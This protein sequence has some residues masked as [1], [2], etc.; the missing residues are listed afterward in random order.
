MGQKFD[1][2]NKDF[3]DENLEENQK[4]GNFKEEVN[5]LR[6]NIREDVE[7]GARK[8]PG[9]EEEIREALL[10][11]ELKHFD[12]D[13]L[14]ETIPLDEI[15]KEVREAEEEIRRQEELKRQEKK[16][17]E[18][19]LRAL[20]IK[21]DKEEA[22]EIKEKQ[23]SKEIEPE[24]IQAI[25]N[26]DEELEKVQSQPKISP[27]LKEKRDNSKI[28][29]AVLGFLV[30]AIIFYFGRGFYFE[31]AKAQMVEDFLI[32]VEERDTSYIKDNLTGPKDLD[33]KIDEKGIEAFFKY[34]DANPAYYKTI[35]ESLNRQLE[36]YD[37]NKE[38]VG[39]IDDNF[40]LRHDGKTYRLEVKPYYFKGNFN[41]DEIH[42]NLADNYLA[43][44]EPNKEYGP[45]FP[46]RYDVD[47]VY[48]WKFG[49]L[50][51]FRE[52]D[53]FNPSP[54]GPKEIVNMDLSFNIK[55]VDISTNNNEA[56]IYVND[57]DTGLTMADLEDGILSGYSPEAT[58]QLAIDTPWGEFTSEKMIL[59]ELGD[60]A[61]LNINYN[62]DNLTG[63]VT[64]ALTQFVRDDVRA[65]NNLNPGEYTNLADPERSRRQSIIGA[66]SVLGSSVNSSVS[67]VKIDLG[68]MDLSRS[69]DQYLMSVNMK[70]AEYR[71]T[72]STFFSSENTI[73]YHL[74]VYMFYD[75][76]NWNIY[77]ISDIGGYDPI[78]E[79][80]YS[81]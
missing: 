14:S 26:L 71:S 13:K 58:L 40:R 69:D 63:S 10:V 75:G 38:D 79:I 70:Y 4:E 74:K 6:D 45:F 33:M 12:E 8:L 29:G 23:E 20:F 39:D 16:E 72:Q 28:F 56:K 65:F 27:V 1:D 53:L 19:G 11:E 2:E 50:K 55:T 22:K 81:L 21:A 7:A 42:L 57:Q 3:I 24:E 15:Q 61:Q 51:A 49:D 76:N 17:K 41:Y 67:E 60:E 18:A 47:A 73:N 64:G 36:H 54:K 5:T 30:V 52:F 66:M 9:L 25:E 31:K 34:L 37:N 59:G 48:P 46:G 78:N 43:K 68:S 35:E 44:V 80:T 62:N 77:D 32:A